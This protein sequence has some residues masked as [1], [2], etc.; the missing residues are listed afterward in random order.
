M[1]SLVQVIYCSEAKANLQAA[2]IEQILLYAREHNAKKSI[3]G[4]LTFDSKFF[5][6]VLEGERQAVSD[7]ITR[8][9]KDP[10]HHRFC[11]LC[12]NTI[13]KR[14]FASWSMAY[15]GQTKLN[16]TVLLNYSTDGKFDPFVFTTESALMLLRDLANTSV[17]SS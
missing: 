1:T 2:D 9:G 16:K 12:A 13:Y 3:T 11:L 15:V 14:D 10:R 6:Q 7:L 17:V 4:L 8:I 5:L